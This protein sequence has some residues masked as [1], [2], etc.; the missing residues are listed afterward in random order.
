MGTLADRIKE[1]MQATG[2]SNAQ[3]AKAAGV[4]QPTAHNWGTGKT[5]AIKGEPLLA[6]AAVLEVTPNWLATGKGEKFPQ[7]ERSSFLVKENAPESGTPQ[8]PWIAEAV[9]TLTAMSVED[10]RAAVLNLRVFCQNLGPPGNSNNFS[11]AA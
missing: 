8:D 4:R 5:K 10:R 2:L 3:L 1:R 7:F 11:V 9:R 6:A